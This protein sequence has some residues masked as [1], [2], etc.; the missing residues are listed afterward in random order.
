MML[1]VGLAT[2]PWMEFIA[3]AKIII[4]TVSLLGTQS[5]GGRMSTLERVDA[6]AQSPEVLLPPRY[7][8]LFS[9]C[10]SS[11]SSFSPFLALL[12]LFRQASNHRKESKEIGQNQRLTRFNTHN[13]VGGATAQTRSFFRVSPSLSSAQ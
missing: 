4:I 9:L 11:S 8:D 10:L 12:D 5:D 6:G 13:F 3:T 7:S 2:P 1:H